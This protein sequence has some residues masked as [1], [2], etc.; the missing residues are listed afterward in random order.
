MCLGR[1]V[2]IEWS[3]CLQLLVSMYRIKHRNIPIKPMTLFSPDLLKRPP[4]KRVIKS[5]QVSSSSCVIDIHYFLLTAKK[6]HFCSINRIPISFA[7][8]LPWGKTKNK[9]HQQ[10]HF[11]NSQRLLGKLHREWFV[12]NLFLLCKSFLYFKSLHL[13][14]MILFYV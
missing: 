11:I 13:F 14:Y 5:D 10:N 4:E 6:F 2:T 8:R 1:W 9:V 3:S 7:G 12:I